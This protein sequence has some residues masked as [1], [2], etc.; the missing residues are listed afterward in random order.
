MRKLVEKERRT[1]TK[2]A[3]SIRKTQECVFPCFFLVKYS[4]YVFVNVIS[5]VIL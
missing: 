1:T 2:K 4:N 3:M 5:T